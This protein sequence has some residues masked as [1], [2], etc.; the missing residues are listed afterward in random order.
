MARKNQPRGPKHGRWSGDR[1]TIICKTCG[2]S[3]KVVPRRKDSARYCS[4][5]CHWN[6]AGGPVERICEICEAPFIAKPDQVEKGFARFCSRTCFGAWL[7]IDNKGPNHP[8]WNGGPVRRICQ[9]CGDAFYAR[10]DQVERG[11]G[12]FCS[13]KCVGAS[14]S[15]RFAGENSPRWT[16]GMDELECETCGQMFT[17]YVT[18]KEK[19]NGKEQ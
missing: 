15:T 2:E 19:N 5:E 11:K 1:V 3:F 9:E 16:G 4:Q 6:R 7:S 14:L 12:I 10:P 18:A 8:R 17:R 13:K